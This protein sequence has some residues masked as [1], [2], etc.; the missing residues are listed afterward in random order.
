MFGFLRLGFRLGSDT[1]WVAGVA[2]KEL[3]LPIP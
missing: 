2:A 3:T 1:N